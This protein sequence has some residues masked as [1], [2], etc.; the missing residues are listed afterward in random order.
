MSD[1]R[2]TYVTTETAGFVVAG[3]RVPPDAANPERAQTGFEMELTAGEADY[4]LAQGTIALKFASAKKAKAE[5]S[6]SSGV[7]GA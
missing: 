7:E 1:E 5:K 3:R 2:K 6:A 4:D